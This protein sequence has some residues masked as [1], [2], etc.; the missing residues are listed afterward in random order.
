LRHNPLYHKDLTKYE[1]VGLRYMI[2]A[3]GPVRDRVDGS[4]P[5]DFIDSVRLHRRGNHFLVRVK[6]WGYTDATVHK[7]LRVRLGGRVG[8]RFAAALESTLNDLYVTWLGWCDDVTTEPPKSCPNEVHAKYAPD[9]VG[10]H[11]VPDNGLWRCVGCGWLIDTDGTRIRERY[12][13][14]A[15]TPRPAVRTSGYGGSEE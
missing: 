10:V 4:Y 2:N 8:P 14:V 9:P 7:H 3:P 5:E 6:R 1:T 12:D 13:D 11:F 15:E